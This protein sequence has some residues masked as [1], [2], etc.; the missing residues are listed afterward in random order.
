[1]IINPKLSREHGHKKGRYHQPKKQ[2]PGVTVLNV[3]HY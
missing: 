3:N 2:K 1:M